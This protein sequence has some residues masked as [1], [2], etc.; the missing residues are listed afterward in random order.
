[1]RVENGNQGVTKAGWGV[2]LSMKSLDVVPAGTGYSTSKV[3]WLKAK[4]CL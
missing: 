3:V 4:E 1:M 2:Y